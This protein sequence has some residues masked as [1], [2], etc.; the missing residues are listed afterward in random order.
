MP[1]SSARHG[2][3]RFCW[4]LLASSDPAGAQAFYGALAG[5]EASAAGETPTVLE[6]DGQRVAAL[7]RLPAELAQ[8]GVPSH[9]R[10]FIST[11]DVDAGAERCRELGATVLGEPVE[12]GD[13]ARVVPVFDPQGANFALW[14]PLALVGADSIGAR[15]AICWWELNTRDVGTAREFYR[16]LF[17]WDVEEVHAAGVDYVTFKKGGAEVAGLQAQ[18]PEWGDAPPV[19][20]TYIGVDTADAAAE[21]MVEL[22]AKIVGGPLD[23]PRGRFAV[24]HDPQDAVVGVLS[25]RN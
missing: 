1:S 14:Q 20:L 3:G 21:R 15:D 9:W 24:A 7:D 2:P 18:R 23:H 22:G 25:T 13:W 6:H 8:H 19:W 4:A 17:A 10:S 5:W 11:D 16:G 12:L